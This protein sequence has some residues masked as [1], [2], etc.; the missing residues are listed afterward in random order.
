[1]NK[2]TLSLLLCLPLLPLLISCFK[3]K[4]A[5]SSK[6]TQRVNVAKEGVLID[7]KYDSRL[8]NLVPGYKILT[9]GLTNNGVDIM[10][11]NP[12]SDKWEV[13]DAFGKTR[14]AITS[15][16]IKEPGL[17]GRLPPKMQQLLEYP[18]GISVGYSE[19]IDLF[20]PN[21][22]SLDSFRSIAFYS[23]ERKTTFDITA[24]LENTRQ[25]PIDPQVDA[26]P[27]DA[28]TAK[29]GKKLRKP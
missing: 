24:D 11:L 13:V 18:T 3:S 15:L 28:T 4:D 12:L 5:E 14:K 25:V 1:M 20:F 10:R 6:N 27:P 21:N 2:K 23:A 7:A 9:V 26:P 17:Y 16:R 19:T 29:K 22:V 8:D